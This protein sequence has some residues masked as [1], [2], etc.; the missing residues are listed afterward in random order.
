LRPSTYL[1]SRPEH[2]DRIL[3]G[4][5]HR[6]RAPSTSMTG[7]VATF[8][9]KALPALDGEDWLQR[10]RAIQP[11]FHPASVAMH[12][13]IVV[14]ETQ[15]MLRRWEALDQVDVYTELQALQVSIIRRTML[16]SCDVPVAELTQLLHRFLLLLESYPQL[17]SA[18]E[19]PLTRE[20]L[21][22]VRALEQIVY[23]A[24]RERRGRPPGP[25]MLWVL[26]ES[27]DEHGRPMSDETIR[28]DLLT[29]LRA[30]FRSVPMALAWTFH[31]LGQNPTQEAELARAAE[32]ASSPESLAQGSYPVQVL[33]EAMRLHP[34][35]PLIARITDADEDF[36]GFVI[37]KGSTVF[38]CPWLLHRD[39]RFFDAPEAFLPERWTQSLEHGLPRSVYLPFGG[40][41]RACH[42]RAYGMM[43]AVTQLALITRAFRL[44]PT[45]AHV[46]PRLTINGMSPEGGL[47]ARLIRRQPNA[48]RS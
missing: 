15:A 7:A 18:P 44:A 40:G 37:S 2:V 3:H 13:G 42:A 9:G 19:H 27:K 23:A 32:D 43:D 5:N 29:S 38:V 36:D 12:A 48:V 4:T 26:L 28:D 14:D 34:I 21:E 20:F 33:K 47:P 22:V 24:I 16:G 10:R 39:P 41:T 46:E 6:F 8:Y 35:Y 25:D 31:V 45:Q 17:M 1:F 30:A 11:T